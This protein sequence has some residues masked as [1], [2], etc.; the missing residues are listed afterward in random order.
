MQ[1]EKTAIQVAR[2]CKAG[3]LPRSSAK[4]VVNIRANRAP[5]LHACSAL[6]RTLIDVSEELAY[7]M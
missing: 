1:L 5:R 3:A 7:L 6:A 4:A 2:C